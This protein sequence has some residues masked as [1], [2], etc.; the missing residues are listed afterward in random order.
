MCLFTVIRLKLSAKGSD[1]RKIIEMIAIVRM[2]FRKSKRSIEQ[3]LDK[4]RNRVTL[5]NTGIHR[6]R[7]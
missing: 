1:N 3:D 4:W 5:E 2:V 6:E 7:G